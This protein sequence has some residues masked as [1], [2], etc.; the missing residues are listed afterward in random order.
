M[1]TVTNWFLLLGGI[2]LFLYGINYMTQALEAAAGDNLRIVLERMTRKGITAFFTG[3]FVTALIQSSGA[4]GV[5]VVGF[6][7]AELM[8]LSQGL[9][10]MLGANIG[11]TITSWIISF[12]IQS[13]APLILFIGTLLYLFIRNRTVRKIGAI[14]LGFGMLFVGIYLMDVATQALNLGTIISSFLDNYSNPILLMLFGIVFTAIIQSSS[15]S[16]GMLQVLVMAV[17]GVTLPSVVYMILG[18]NIGASAPI[19]IAAFGGNR[20][21]KR[22]A[23]GNVVTKVLGALLFIAIMLIFPSSVSMIEGW[24]GDVARQI[25]IFHLLFNLISSVVLCP[26]VPLIAKA[27]TKIMPDREKEAY[28]ARRLLY[29]GKEVDL[30]TTISI[31]QT[32]REILRMGN[33]ACENLEIAIHSCLMR[34]ASQIDRVFDVEK[35][36]NFLN[37][38]ITGYL[39]NLHGRNMP[40]KDLERVGM[41]FRVVSDIER[42]GDHAENIAEYAQILTSGSTKFSDIAFAELTETAQTAVQCLRLSLEVYENEDFS[43]L[44]EVSEIEE[45]VDD[46]QDRFIANHI[47]RLKEGECSPNGGVIFSDMVSDLERCSDHAINIAFAINGEK[48]TVEVKKSYVITRGGN[49]E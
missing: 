9:F 3:T 34:D 21:S 45:T 48:G 27:I 5:M 12:K 32:K 26:F 13:V 17:P 46:F 30:T 40:D 42:I 49:M 18:M 35:T 4:C 19:V 33:I 31:T 43:K 20:A 37:H 14:I 36:L 16:I 7:S 10:V 1:D 39:V 23:V 22:A 44:S 28:I 2:A 38:E 6:I 41:M 29:I 8:T 15:A 11:T 24:S 47:K 25:A